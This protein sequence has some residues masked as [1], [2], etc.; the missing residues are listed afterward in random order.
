MGELFD[1]ARHHAD[2]QRDWAAQREA[3]Q[4][5]EKAITYQRAMEF[6]QLMREY[7]IPT[8]T[9]GKYI[10]TKEPLFGKS[11]AIV[12]ETARGWVAI[13]PSPSGYMGTEDPGVF[14]SEA[15]QVYWCERLR[16][17]AQIVHMSVYGQ[18]DDRALAAN[19]APE[20][21]SEV[22]QRHGII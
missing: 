22:L 14:V 13:E 17:S 9:I 12:Q 10:R 4:E 7:N 19:D 5:R 16:S 20:R 18:E 1:S 15:G 11:R 21:V 2:R 8:T 3:E 6:A